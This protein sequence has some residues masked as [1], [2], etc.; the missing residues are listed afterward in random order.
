MNDDQ[1]FLCENLRTGLNAVRTGP[2]GFPC[3]PSQAT[4]WRLL[5]GLCYGII[6]E[7]CAD[8]ADEEGRPWRRAAQATWD[9]IAS[10]KAGVRDPDVAAQWFA[11]RA[12]LPLMRAPEP[13]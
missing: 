1:R 10:A 4:E 11:A 8:E 7:V 2:D 6:T 13:R 3:D 12:D 9:L 5:S